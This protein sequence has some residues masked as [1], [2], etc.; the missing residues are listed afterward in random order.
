MKVTVTRFQKELSKALQASGQNLRHLLKAE[1]TYLTRENHVDFYLKSSLNGYFFEGFENESFI[2]KNGVS[3]FLNPNLRQKDC[4]EYFQREASGQTSVSEDPH[5][6]EFLGVR[7]AAVRQLFP[8]DSGN[9]RRVNCFE[10]LAGFDHGLEL[11]I[12]FKKVARSVWLLH[13][14]AFAFEPPASIFRVGHGCD[15][16]TAYMEGVVKLEDDHRF[17]PKVGF[18]VT[19]GLRVRKCVMR[20][21]V[22]LQGIDTGD[23]RML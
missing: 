11:A 5:F 19:P 20:C 22:Y 21:E 9:S 13:K 12:C 15:V 23:E 8:L 14:L 4:Y 1:Q 18:M 6:K 2:S 17:V 7:Y 3:R 16:D 10:E